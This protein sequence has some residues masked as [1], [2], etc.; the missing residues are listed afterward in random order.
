MGLLGSD[1]YANFPTV[2]RKAIV[3]NVNIDGA[4]GIYY[5]MKDVVAMGPEHSSLA[6]NVDSAARELGYDLSPDPMPEEVS[7]IRSDQYS[8]VLQGIPAVYI[9]DGVKAVDGKVDG[10][11]VLK[12]WLNTRYHTPGDNM[13]QPL[14]FESAAKGT[15]LNFLIGYE[16]AQQDER[17]VWNQGDFFG[18]TFGGQ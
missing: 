17:P 12:L 13:E 4:P 18:T 8:F 5:A 14:D 6:K 16:V 10:L 11:N 2:S 7:F 3:A 1:Y 15:R 9:T